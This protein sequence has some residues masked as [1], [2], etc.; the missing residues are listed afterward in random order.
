MQE[1]VQ[2][3]QPKANEK[4]TTKEPIFDGKKVRQLFLKTL[5]ELHLESSNGKRGLVLDEETEKCVELICQYICREHRFED[6]EH[7]FSFNKGILLMGNFG[8]GKTQIMRSY[9]ITV[10]TIHGNSQKVGI[11]SCESLNKAFLK[12]DEYTNQ[13]EGFAALEKYCSL[14]FTGKELIFDDL[15]SEETTI[16]DYG[17][18]I[19]VMAHVLSER[20]NLHNKGMITHLTTN[21]NSKDIESKYG[22][23]ITSRIFEMFNVIKLGAKIDSVDYRKRK[24]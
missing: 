20:Y 24:Y 13:R 16:M 17:N 15:G 2:P 11:T 18:K 8:S 19:C 4:T 10:N 3:L 14:P 5:N 6:S 21:E 1:A 7:L 23:R 12:K 9:R 22:G